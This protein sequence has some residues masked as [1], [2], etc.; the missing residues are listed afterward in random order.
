MRIVSWNCN[1]SLHNRT[2]KLEE[3]LKLD[4]DIYI[5]QECAN[6]SKYGDTRYRSIVGNGFW[7]GS[8]PYKGLAVFSAKKDV[9]IEKL[10]WPD[11]GLENFIPIR[12]NDSFNVLAVWTM[13]KYIQEFYDYKELNKS[14]IDDN[15]IMIGDFNSNFQFDKGH[16]K[17]KKHT[18]VVN[19]LKS[20]G[21]EDIYHTLT[22]EEQGKESVPTFFLYRHEDQP[23]HIDHCFANPK[24]VSSLKIETDLRW[25]KMSDH[26]PVTIEV[27]PKKPSVLPSQ[28][29]SMLNCQKV[30]IDVIDGMICAPSFISEDEWYEILQD[31]SEATKTYLYCH[32]MSTDYRGSCYDIGKKFGV[33]PNSLNACNSNLGKKAA[34]KLGGIER[35]DGD[36]A[37]P[38]W[39]IPMNK[40][41]VEN[42]YFVWQMRPELVQAATR[43]LKECGFVGIDF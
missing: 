3:I 5:I 41:C 2:E 28:N 29:P 14:R 23:F 19:Q 26:M 21:I 12:V 20:I 43:Y 17:G 38:Y 15:I 10:D 40:G 1:C 9:K 39:L 4:A 18:D 33:N 36:G 8:T 31:S 22:G 35:Y 34:K 27:P 16:R 30:A 7:T 6:P 25:L 42:K 32:L 37:F 24:L 11:D 13:N